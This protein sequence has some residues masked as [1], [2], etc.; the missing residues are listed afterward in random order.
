[1]RSLCLAA[2]IG[3]ALLRHGLAADAPPMPVKPEGSALSERGREVQATKLH[4]PGLGFSTGMVITQLEGLGLRLVVLPNPMGLTVPRFGGRV[5]AREAV[6]KLA[7]ANKLELT[8]LEGETKVILW[9]KVPEGQRQVLTK[10]MKSEDAII[11]RKAVWEIALTED[12]E[13]F[14]L[15]LAGA[16]IGAERS[17]EVAGILAKSRRLRIACRLMS[18][19]GLPFWTWRSATRTPVCA[20]SHWTKS[21]GS[22]WPNP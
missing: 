7:E 8:W 17:A 6:K 12:L 4:G 3:L 21:H 19:R 11:R 13:L 10:E 5:T 2:A 15:L 20:A 18:R 9:C 22:N 1:M 16:D 14:R